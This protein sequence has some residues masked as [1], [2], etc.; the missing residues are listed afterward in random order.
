MIEERANMN[1]TSATTSYI[2]SSQRLIWSIFLLI[3]LFTNSIVSK[4]SYDSSTI[5]W[6][7]YSWRIKEGY[8]RPGPN[9]FTNDSVSLTNGTLSMMIKPLPDG[10]WSSAEIYT[11]RSLG[12]GTYQWVISTETGNLPAQV[13]LGM[14]TWEDWAKEVHNREIDIEFAKWG[15][16]S[17]PTN[18][19]FTIQP[20]RVKG[21]IKRLTVFPS[22]GQTRAEFT[23]S[24]CGVTFRLI[25][26]GICF[27]QH[28]NHTDTKYRMSN[29][30]EKVHINLWLWA[31]KPPDT[32]GKPVIVNFK[33]FNFI[34]L[35]VTDP[36]YIVRG[37]SSPLTWPSSSTPITTPATSTIAS[38]S[39][40]NNLNIVNN[41][42]ESPGICDS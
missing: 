9:Y 35:D 17:D 21:N 33:S 12:Y 27:G 39:F 34:P 18:A 13:T 36:D 30:K 7:G 1:L 22:S 26:Q 2:V 40:S 3:V 24:P 23:W 16:P 6:S 4:W 25:K 20:H 28:L 14:F 11:V 42:L 8:R 37:R 38:Q 41:Y 19:Q 32:N 15:K 31:G 5:Y 29:G 10:N